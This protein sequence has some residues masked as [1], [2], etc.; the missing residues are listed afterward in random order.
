M[1]G[2]KKKNTV[3]Y[4]PHYI[5]EGKKMRYIEAKYGNDGY[6]SW[7]K[8]LETLAGAENHYINLNDDIESEILADKCK[9]SL[10]V[11][12]SLLDDLSRLGAINKFLWENKVIWSQIFVESIRDAYRKRICD[13]LDFS[14]LC[15]YLSGINVISFDGNSISSAGNTGKKKEEIKKEEIGNKKEENSTESP[16]LQSGDKEKK[17]VKKP[18][19]NPTIH[20]QCRQ[21]FEAFYLE[22]FKEEYYF[23]KQDAGNLKNLLNSIN[24]KIREK[25][26]IEDVSEEKTIEGF[27]YFLAR[28]YETADQFIKG[29]FTISTLYSKF[30][31]I[32]LK[33]SGNGK[34]QNATNDRQQRIDEVAQLREL[35]KGIVRNGNQ[36]S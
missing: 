5:G 6:A 15:R 19:K 12:F 9:V 13:F 22:K 17:L 30:N 21:I 2:R 7:F 10:D 26:N 33:F 8:I 11:L 32:F 24:F 29:S 31:E 18:V 34:Q 14:N 35:A 4:F 3:D 16:D 25:N 23:K 36:D 27:K 20:F 1:A 28:A